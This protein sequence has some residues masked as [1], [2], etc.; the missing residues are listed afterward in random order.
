MLTYFYWAGVAALVILSL[1]LVG[2]AMGRWRST[3]VL[4]T[5]ALIL[6]S[7]TYYLQFQQIFVKR[8]GGVMTITAPD[9]HVH[10]AVT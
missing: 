4:A 2:A 9:G 10:L 8:W 3:T 5:T 6:G 1:G 7:A